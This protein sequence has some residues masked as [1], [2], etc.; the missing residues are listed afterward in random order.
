ME[1]NTEKGLGKALAL[2]IVVIILVIGAAA[3]AG[4]GGFKVR[5]AIES[6]KR[7]QPEH[8]YGFCPICGKPGVQRSRGPDGFDVCET[9]HTY[10]SKD[11]VYPRAA[12][13]TKAELLFTQGDTRVYRFND[14]GRVQYFT[15]HDS[16]RGGGTGAT[17]K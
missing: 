2:V 13:A 1:D 16:R 9:G 8:A 6:L 7:S 3:A 15:E 14:E 12:R 17:E 5:D 4:Y 10:P 11:A